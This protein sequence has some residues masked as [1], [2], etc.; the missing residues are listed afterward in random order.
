MQTRAISHTRAGVAVAARKA[1]TAAGLLRDR[2]RTRPAASGAV[3]AAA[4]AAGVPGAALRPVD[5]PRRLDR[6]A[7]AAE[8]GG[9]HW[10]FLRELGRVSPGTFA[11]AL[12]G[13]RAVGPDGAVVAADGRS[14]RDLSVRVGP[15]GGDPLAGRRVRRAVSVGGSAG[16]AASL[17]AEANYFHWMFDALPRVDLIRRAGFEPDR[18]YAPLGRPFHAETL[19]RAG[20]DPA[21]VIDAA[22]A[23]H[24]RADRLIAAGPPGDTGNP[25]PAARAFL[26]GLFADVIEGVRP[27]RRVYLSRGD[28]ARRRVLGEDAL[29]ARLARLGYERHELG[30]RSAAAQARL[31][32][33][34]THVI[35]PHGAGLT[36]L[37]FCPPGA[38]V[39]ELFH[40]GYVNVCYW[41]LANLGGVGY[42]W[43][44]GEGPASPPGRCP[45]LTKA[46]ILVAPA[47]LDR[48]LRALHRDAPARRPV[49]APARRAA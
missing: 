22:A 8:A 7:P 35:A 15:P 4:L 48:A 29:F 34:A 47:A 21:T 33:E 16:V 41:S 5:P 26:R 44:A 20:I 18:W 42:H 2:L 36:N 38:R 31:F 49:A 30:G 40:P 25:T 37:V 23:G 12:P 3:D 46:D 17:S 13:G 43:L 11:V 19:R 39:L 9:V 24:L 27:F 28:A 14:V 1:R 32:A 10:K 45:G 6:A